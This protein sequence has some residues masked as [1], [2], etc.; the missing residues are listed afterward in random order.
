[1]PNRP[2]SRGQEPS[3]ESRKAP[4]RKGGPARKPPRL[5]R[6]N[7]AQTL[8]RCSQAARSKFD[9]AEPVFE[10]IQ[11]ALKRFD[12][13]L[14]VAAKQHAAMSDTRDAAVKEAIAPLVTE[15]RDRIRIRFGDLRLAHGQRRRELDEFTVMFFGKTMA[16]KSTTIEALTAGDGSTIGAGD[17]DFTRNVRGERWDGIT[18]IDTPGLLGFREELHG[19]AQ[20]YVDRAD[21]I[22]MVVTDDSIEP[23]LFLRM[24]EV[25]GQNKH[26]VVLLNVKAAN[27]PI[28]LG[29]A[30][31]AFDPQE[32]EQRISFIRD[33]LREVFPGDPATVIPYCAN[34]A[35][36]AQ[37]AVD[38]I[39]REYL[40]RESRIDDV[41]GYIAGTIDQRGVSIRAT[42]AFDSLQHYAQSIA[43]DLEAE[44]PAIE[45]Q[46]A[47]LSR[48][49]QEAG[50]LFARVVLD[51]QR[52]LEGFK[53]HFRRVHDE[54]HE[55]AWAFARE[56]RTGS[57]NEAFKQ[58]C[59]WDEV[60]RRRKEI[61]QD[62][63][64][65]TRRNLEYFR[66]SLG[67][68]LT[69]AVSLA[70]AEDQGDFRLGDTDLNTGAWKLRLGKGIR[71]VGTAAASLGG[72]WAGAE[73]GAAAGVAIGGPVGA[74]IGGLLGLFGGLIGGYVANRVASK[75]GDL[76]TSS[77]LKDRKGAQRGL[78]EQMR[79]V[80]WERHRAL[81]EELSTWVLELVRPTRDGVEQLLDAYS[82][83]LQAV[84]QQGRALVGELHRARH[85][86]ARQSF[87]A[88]LRSMHPA[89]QEGRATLVDASQWMQ[90]RAKILVR[91][92]GRR[93]VMGLV[94]GRGGE[95][96]RTLREHTGHPVDVIED[97]GSG[98]SPRMVCEALAP[99]RVPPSGVEV[100][101][102]KGVQVTLP[103][104]EAGAVYGRQ[105][106]NLM[107]AEEVLGT[108][109]VL[110]AGDALDRG[111]R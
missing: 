18:L 76:V 84:S 54:L 86:L 55:L 39:A 67:Q 104:R 78:R 30:E 21:L 38:P 101:S 45:R 69:A 29:E 77:G 48:K 1:M 51:S 91:G 58:A 44:L 16:G 23:E 61:Q 105:R 15:K 99:G 89:F 3:I 75:A 87:D 25:R 22:C 74:A 65:R 60:E 110:R 31:D 106:R 57:V 98:L 68:D 72:A 6:V 59:R 109:I 92:D 28:L 73:L 108:P 10:Q 71:T 11:A 81:H 82:Q 5:G 7:L 12:K 111:S 96:I 90:Y 26:L 14:A 35:F 52:D 97:D 34:A 40:W 94:L 88:L 2:A 102:S 4:V 64:D 13:A 103:H 36:E 70:A 53:D 47:E 8:A 9:E 85:A 63:I 62:V 24:R 56:D 100:A 33:R 50:R 37:R 27:N 17:P 83:A 42:A 80:L 46:L 20:A 43:A 95:F 66:D 49:R 93:P 19:V 107:L 79:D 41:I 32:M